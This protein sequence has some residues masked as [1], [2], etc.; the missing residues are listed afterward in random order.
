MP[1]CDGGIVR[2]FDI[3]GPYL[4]V[5]L[6]RHPQ[7][8]PNGV[9]CLRLQRKEVIGPGEIGQFAN[10]GGGVRIL[11]Q[12]FEDL[13]AANPLR[14]QNHEIFRRV[15]LLDLRDRSDG[16]ALLTTANLLTALDQHDPELGR[17]IREDAREHHEISLFEDAQRQRH[18]RKQNR[19]KGEH[20][21]IGHLSRQPRRGAPA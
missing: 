17:L 5:E 18:V 8:A 12:P 21:K 9:F 1:G 7:C 20:R 3:R 15:Q 6:A 14:D 19:T 10:P 11:L 2:D 16:E 4:V 13:D